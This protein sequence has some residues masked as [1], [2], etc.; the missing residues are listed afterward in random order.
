MQDGNL[1][2]ALFAEPGVVAEEFH[3]N[4]KRDK[5]FSEIV[6]EEAREVIVT[7]RFDLL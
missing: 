7:F 3:L 2:G 1:M 5:G 4:F 6:G